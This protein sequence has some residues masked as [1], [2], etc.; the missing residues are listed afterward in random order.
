M[1]RGEPVGTNGVGE[2]RYCVTDIQPGTIV[3]FGIDDDMVVLVVANFA[4]HIHTGEGDKPSR[5]LVFYGCMCEEPGAYE[6][7]RLMHQ[8][9]L[10]KES[11]TV[12]LPPVYS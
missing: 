6:E 1:M 12:L 4:S 8:D 9:F 3:R 11:L 2:P 10:L 7:G 5:H